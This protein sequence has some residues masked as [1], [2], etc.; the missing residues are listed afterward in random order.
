MYDFEICMQIRTEA[1]KQV[2]TI[3]EKAND[4]ITEAIE[5]FAKQQMKRL[6]DSPQP[7][8]PAVP[9]AQPLT[10]PPPA[11]PLSGAAW[12]EQTVTLQSQLLIMLMTNTHRLLCDFS[13]VYVGAK[14][15][16]KRI[17]LKLI[18]TPIKAMGIHSPDL[19]K[20][21]EA[22]PKGIR[23]IDTC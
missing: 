11:A 14:D 13:A 12:T 17:L 18:E 9:P 20:F 22:C 16:V 23:G 5:R 19:A 21:L 7:P 2:K 3:Y 8:Q 6:H 10:V 1:Q 15:D 4:A